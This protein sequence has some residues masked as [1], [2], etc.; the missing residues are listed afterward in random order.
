MAD[1]RQLQRLMRQLEDPLVVCM[2]CGMCRAVCPVFAQTGREADVARGKLVLLD[3]LMQAGHAGGP[4]SRPAAAAALPAVRQL[5]RQL[6][7]RSQRPGDLPEVPRHPGRLP[8]PAA[9]QEGDIPPT[10][11]EDGKGEPPLPYIFLQGSRCLLR[12]SAKAR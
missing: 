3:G 11:L 4:R 1:I 2:R 12:T 8:G 6:P 10:Y 7:E 5:R 9:T